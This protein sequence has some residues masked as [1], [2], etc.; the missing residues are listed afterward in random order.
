MKQYIDYEGQWVKKGQRAFEIYSPELVATQ[1]EY[2]L[3]YENV[4]NVKDSD[5]QRV[6][7]NALSILD[8]TRQRLKLW[9]VSDAQIEELEE[10]KTVRNSLYYYADYSGVIT[11]K[12]VNEG[13]WVTEGTTIAEVVNLG[14]I[15]V[16]ANVYENEL[17]K[18]RVGQPVTVTLSGYPDKPISGRIDYINPFINPDTRTAEIRITTSNPGLMMKP[19]MYVKAD[20]ETGRTSKY[21][22]VPRNSVIRTGKQD[23]VYIEK[24]D[25]VFF[26]QEVVIAGERE[27]NYLISEG[28]SSGDIIV[29][30]AG[31]LLDSESRIRTGTMDTHNHGDME[32]ENTNNKNEPKINPDQDA[33]KDMEHKH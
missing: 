2:L 25:N 28:L 17:G 16:I 26:P 24:R 12:Y 33:L 15:W 30:S 11:K 29:T 14:S 19:G 4:M 20:I 31:F 7:E 27:G 32:M 23:I 22:V 6:Y 18:V 21:I 13:S 8:A 1:K 10:T 3:A 5:Y 9:F